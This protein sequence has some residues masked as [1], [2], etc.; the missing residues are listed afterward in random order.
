MAQQETAASAAPPE[1]V[2]PPSPQ[3][4]QPHSACLVYSPLQ[5]DHDSSQEQKSAIKG[6]FVYALNNTIH[7]LDPASFKYSGMLV[8]P[9]A[10]KVNALAARQPGQVPPTSASGTDKASM[11]AL[12]KHGLSP[13]SSPFSAA[14]LVSQEHHTTDDQAMASSHP[15]ETRTIIASAGDD[16]MVTEIKAV[17]WLHNGTTVVSGDRS[18]YITVWDPYAAK[19]LKRASMDKS[20]IS[21][22][23]ACPS[24][25]QGD[26]A[27][28]GYET[29]DVLI[30]QLR[31]SGA[32]LLRRLH[33]HSG[34]IQS[35]AWQPYH[36][37]SETG[38]NLIKDDASTF[39]YLASG[40]ADQTIRIWDVDNTRA[41]MFVKIPG[42][43]GKQGQQQN[44]VKAWVPVDWTPDGLMF[45]SFTSRGGC[46]M[47]KIDEPQD[48]VH[49]I[50]HGCQHTRTV[51][52]VLIW[53]TG[54]FAFSFGMDR[55]IIVWDLKRQEGIVRVDGLAGPVDAVDVSLLDPGRLAIANGN[56]SISLW[57]TLG[58]DMPF[59][60]IVIDRLT[61]R[62]RCLAWH[63]AEEG[64]IAFGL[65][66]GKIG[67][68]DRV[69]EW[70]P[71]QALLRP[72]KYKDKRKAKSSQGPLPQFFPSYH[73]SGVLSIQWCSSKAFSA[74]IP[75][76]LD[77][78][79]EERS[80]CLVTC[81][82]DGKI[83]VTVAS[84]ASA[85]NASLDLDIVLTRQNPAWYEELRLRTGWSRLQRRAVAIHP[86]EDLMAIGNAD[87][88]LEVVELRHFRVVHVYHGHKSKMSQLAWCKVE[89]GGTGDSTD[90]LQQQP[91]VPYLLACGGGD[92]GFV[93][94]LHLDRYASSKNHVD[95][96][97][98]VSV[99][100][101]GSAHSIIPS[102]SCMQ[103]F[104]CHP[105]R[106]KRRGCSSLAWSPFFSTDASHLPI[107]RFASVGY[108]GSVAVCE[109]TLPTTFTDSSAVLTSDAVA[110]A[111]STAMVYPTARFVAH[112]PITTTVRW[113]LTDEHN[114]Y[115]GG[116][117]WRVCEW[118]WRKYKMGEEA[119]MYLDPR[120]QF[121]SSQET[122]NI[123]GRKQHQPDKLGKR[124]AGS[125]KT[126]GIAAKGLVND[127]ETMSNKRRLSIQ[128]GATEGVEEAG[129]DPVVPLSKKRAPPSR[130]LQAAVALESNKR[131]NLFPKSSAAFRTESR[132]RSLLEIIRLTRNLY[133]RSTRG[134][135]NTSRWRRRRWKAMLRFFEADGEPEGQ[136]I[137]VTLRKDVHELNID[138]DGDSDDDEDILNDQVADTRRA[139]SDNDGA[140][141]S[142]LGAITEG[143]VDLVSANSSMQDGSP[144][145]DIRLEQAQEGE[146]DDVGDD[147]HV[148]DSEMFAKESATEL[149]EDEATDVG[150][151]GDTIFYGSREAIISLAQMESQALADLDA[152]SGRNIFHPGTGMG[153]VFPRGTVPLRR[154]IQSN[155]TSNF[156]EDTKDSHTSRRAQSTTSP[157]LS[158]IPISYWLGDVPDMMA[159]LSSTSSLGVQDWIGLALSPMGGVAAWRGMM[160]QMAK[161]C[162]QEGEIHAAVLCF[163]GIGQV[164][165][166]V[167]AYRANDM[168][169]EALMLLKIRMWEDDQDDGRTDGQE[170]ADYGEAMDIGDEYAR[171]DAG[172]KGSAP[173]SLLTGVEL[174]ANILAE[175]GR[176]H[177]KR[178]EYEQAAKCQLALGSLLVSS[179]A[180]TQSQRQESITTQDTTQS[181]STPSRARS[182]AVAG[183]GWSMGLQT[184]SR[185]GDIATL[186]AV[187]GLAVLLDDRF[188]QLRI[189]QYN[190][191]VAAKRLS[192]ESRRM[193]RAKCSAA[194]NVT[195]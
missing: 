29:G 46:V 80:S 186:R 20:A 8:G 103:M 38:A 147:G 53:Q 105:S 44:R 130:D 67:M 154:S 41:K 60:S 88:S 191:A 97:T 143:D 4:N 121:G 30:C 51:F 126:Q 12:L 112:H 114:L 142:E 159:I 62:V 167:E 27:A 168:F 52:Q 35:L 177:E 98:S 183:A 40:S 49:K 74:P 129:C 90:D 124:G 185:R 175:W 64:T 79:L 131:A 137:A 193:A 87:G 166:A 128:A 118:D 192:D 36:K 113:S 110:S 33:G 125:G 55:R 56:D 138:D 145:A 189:Q 120:S 25:G 95:P 82:E 169:R 6:W 146:Y 99:M 42:L 173:C 150:A 32:V 85:T 178:D 181:S 104:N 187:A 101:T 91:A 152:E 63:P 48:K 161:K 133:C 195:E 172:Q 31:L 122:S 115:T 160:A 149:K 43:G 109:V 75:E 184:L 19:H 17:E 2:Y 96:T 11:E 157:Q 144:M 174:Q 119:F 26:V 92:D 158:R 135:V 1:N 70:N 59:E 5:T 76:L 123:H 16:R 89:E 72:G 93:S 108:D 57:N 141:E 61:G 34:K 83:L 164:R 182:V 86:N 134:A 155:G 24:P 194:T 50:L 116:S 139:M 153:V 45:M 69:Y 100:T 10:G 179:R 165:E 176:F 65:D 71:Q 132:R 3:W 7:V 102:L 58:Q 163:L 107:Y 106:G 162:L 188:Q 68:I 148:D 170:N 66:N 28:I 127:A 180:K 21:C 171:V 156:S 78:C 151:Y 14:S 111:A 117:D 15:K 47:W 13:G 23:Q 81:A 190:S 73:G 77:L 140:V 18:G 39:T 54:E 22:I 94:V 37:R 84:M 9:H 136:V